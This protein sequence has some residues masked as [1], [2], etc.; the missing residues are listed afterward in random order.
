MIAG[1]QALESTYAHAVAE[2]CMDR[3]RRLLDDPGV[4]AP[5]SS[6]SRFLAFATAVALSNSSAD[7]D[8]NVGSFGSRHRTMARSTAL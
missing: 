2:R 1:S 4:L 5:D 8:R 6:A 7:M 3:L